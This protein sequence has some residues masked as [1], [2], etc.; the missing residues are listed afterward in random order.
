MA[1]LLDQ[2]ATAIRLGAAARERMKAS[3]SIEACAAKYLELF[4]RLRR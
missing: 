4:E 2:P 1:R 3:R